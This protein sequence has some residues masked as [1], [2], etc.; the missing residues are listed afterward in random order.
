[1]LADGL[2]DLAELVHAQGMLL[3]V[4]TLNAGTFDWRAR[5]ER[6]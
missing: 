2:T 4:W 1:M 6:P 3:D 5:P